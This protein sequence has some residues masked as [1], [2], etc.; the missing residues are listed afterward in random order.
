M[1]VRLRFDRVYG[2]KSQY[3][4]KPRDQ[5]TGSPIVLSDYPLPGERTTIHLGSPVVE[6]YRTRELARKGGF[7]IVRRNVIKEHLTEEQEAEEMLAAL[8][9]VPD[10]EVTAWN[11]YISIVIERWIE[12][13]DEQC[14]LK[15]WFSIDPGVAVRAE[16]VRSVRDSPS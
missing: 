14:N 15:R 9:G 1:Q 10:G 7:T 16:R 12:V 5:P 8:D 11:W 13:P 2:T 6:L 4:D 3:G